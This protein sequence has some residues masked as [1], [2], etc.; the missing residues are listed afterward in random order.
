MIGPLRL[1]DA[2]LRGVR[3]NARRRTPL[4]LGAFGERVVHGLGERLAPAGER[5]CA[6]P[7]VVL[8]VA[9]DP[10]GEEL[11]EL[12]AVVL[13]RRPTGGGAE[14]EI[15][16]HPRVDRDLVEEV[17]EAA[18]RV[19][20]PREVLPVDERGLEVD[21]AEVAREVAVPEEGHALGERRGRTEH[22]V[23]PPGDEVLRID[24]L[25]LTRLLGACESGRFGGRR[26]D[27]AVDGLLEPV[28]H[29]LLVFRRRRAERRAPEEVRD[30]GLRFVERRDPVDRRDRRA[31]GRLTGQTE[32]RQIAA[33]VV[34]SEHPRDRE[35]ARRRSGADE[36]VPAAQAERRLLRCLR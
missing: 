28:L 8:G 2:R 4:L 15:P 20:P 31:R 26:L 30:L 12:A 11:H 9:A 25:V 34:Q 33:Q 1:E 13:V 23:H 7:D 24:R 17:A 35:A 36:D 29:C 3:L 32:V 10:H 16:Q 18:E 22:P 6:A 19:L 27:E 21:L 14:V 5:L